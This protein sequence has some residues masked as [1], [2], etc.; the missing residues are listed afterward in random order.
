[1]SK[2]LNVN[3][4]LEIVE[5]EN[6]E[7][8]NHHMAALEKAAEALGRDLAIHYGIK[9]VECDGFLNGMG[10]LCISFGPDREGQPCPE[11]INEKD[12]GGEWE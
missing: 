10:G 9:V 5:E 3:D 7:H 12:T 2:V 4:M 6:L 11:P 1:M 8:L